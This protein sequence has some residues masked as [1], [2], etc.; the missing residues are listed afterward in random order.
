MNPDPSRRKR[1]LWPY[2]VVGL[3][4][5]HASAMMLAVHIAGG[6]SGHTVL[7]EY[8]DRASTWDE[9]RAAKARSEAL[10]WTLDVTPETLGDGTGQRRVSL[11]LRDAAGDPVAGAAVQVRV[12]HRSVG[13]RREAAASAGVDG[14]YVALLPM[15]RAGAYEVETLATLDGQEFRDTRQVDVTA[16]EQSPGAAPRPARPFELD[17][18]R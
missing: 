18:V 8:Y 1:S 17:A 5:A 9:V 2:A 4:G 11:A 7:P 3:L 10:G 12:Y 13:E 14:G 6:S 15:E 16:I